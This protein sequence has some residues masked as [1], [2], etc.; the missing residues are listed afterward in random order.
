MNKIGLSILLISVLVVLLS[1]GCGSRETPALPTPGIIA[2]P[3]TT[4]DPTGSLIQTETGPVQPTALTPAGTPRPTRATVIEQPGL[5]F[6]SYPLEPVTAR[7]SLQQEAIDPQMGNVLVPL[8]LSTEQVQ[9]L[10]EAGVVASPADYPEFHILY[11]ETVQNNLPVFVTSD[12][13]LHAYHLTFDQLLRLCWHRSGRNM[14]SSRAP[15]G[16]TLPGALTRIWLS[17]A[18]CQTRIFSFRMMLKTS[19]KQNST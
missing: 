18:S 16:K 5:V 10:A 1:A 2:S 19:R 15:P 17:A 11:K 3:V 8:A 4:P 13:L 12:A 14:S 9:R 6:A 7:P